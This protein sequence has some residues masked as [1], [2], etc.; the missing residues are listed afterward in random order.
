MPRE[1]RKRPTTLNNVP[2]LVLQQLHTNLAQRNP[3]N[4]YALEASF[5]RARRAVP[6][7]RPDKITNGPNKL[8]YPKGWPLPGGDDVRELKQRLLFVTKLL[9]T[10]QRDV[11]NAGYTTRRERY[12]AFHNTMQDILESNHASLDTMTKQHITVEYLTPD[13]DTI[14]NVRKYRRTYDRMTRGCREDIKVL[15]RSSG[16]VLPFSLM[17]QIFEIHDAQPLS[18]T[19]AVM[20]V[21]VGPWAWYFW[22]VPLTLLNTQLKL[23]TIAFFDPVTLGLL[24]LS[25]RRLRVNQQPGIIVPISKSFLPAERQLER[26]RIRHQLDTIHMVRL[27]SLVRQTD[28]GARVKQRRYPGTPELEFL[29]NRYAPSTQRQIRP[30]AVLRPYLSNND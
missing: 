21:S 26:Q 9:R 11:K 1:K 16:N 15:I 8:M 12:T 29:I 6:P 19:S 30:R 20:A 24:P 28:P 14:T 17:V 5:K 18:F 4:S 23:N 13:G 27:I 2:N 3:K 25:V 22:G 7:S 10:L